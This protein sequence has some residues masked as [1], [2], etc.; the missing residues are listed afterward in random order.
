MEASR[1]KRQLAGLINSKK[2]HSITFRRSTHI[3]QHS[4]SIV[5]DRVDK[6]LNFVIRMHKLCGYQMS[7]IGNM[8]ETP[9]WFEMPGKSTLAECGEKEICVTSTGHEKE[10]LTVTLSAYADG[11]KLPPLVHLSGVRPPPKNEIPTGVVIYMCGAGKKSWANEDSIN[12]WLKRVWG[13]NNQ[14]R[15]FLL[16]DAFRAHL[17]SSVKESVRMKY[18]SDVCYSWGLYIKVTTGRYIMEPTTQIA[19]RRNV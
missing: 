11:T 9:V 14:R 13:M 7:E 12:F 5:D 4:K 18:N 16:W 6:F 2:R 8:D 17:T 1:L 10:K 3:V 15:R 19:H